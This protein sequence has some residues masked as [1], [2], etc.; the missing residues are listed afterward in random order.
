MTVSSARKDCNG[1]ARR[2]AA[3]LW[4]LVILGGCYVH[5]WRSSSAPLAS[6]AAAGTSLRVTTRASA[7]GRAHLYVFSSAQVVG[8]SLVGLVYEAYQRVGDGQW[9]PAQQFERDPRVSVA[10]AD[11]AEV[12]RRE[13]EASPGRSVALV[14]LIVAGIAAAVYGLFVLAYGDCY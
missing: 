7:D 8:D 14:V 9:S 4:M 12:S 10:T 11:I 5:P 3:W 2:T 13:R 1:A 6:V